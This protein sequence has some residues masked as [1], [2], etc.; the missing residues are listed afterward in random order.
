M[1]RYGWTKVRPGYWS[2]QKDGGSYTYTCGYVERISSG[3]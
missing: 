2:Y 1:P 3:E